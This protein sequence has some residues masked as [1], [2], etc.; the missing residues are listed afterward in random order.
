M[1]QKNLIIT[2]DMMIADIIQKY[3]QTINPLMDNGVHYLGCSASS[4][5]SINESLEMG[6][7]KHGKSVK[8]LKELIKMLNKIIE[9]ANLG[10][11]VIDDNDAKFS[12][13]KAAKSKIRE[14]LKK[15]KMKG[16][17]ISVVA[18]GC[19]GLKYGLEFSNKS[20]KNDIIIDE[21]GFKVF[22]EKES[23]EKINGARL[24]YED[25]LQGTGFKIEN[26]N[27]TKKC[28]CGNS[29]R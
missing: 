2:K 27:A 18:G 4:S 16:L 25:G 24:N 7:K 21:D 12:V 13:T 14:M 28:G 29:F 23:M 8:E 10:K 26:P 11:K 5:E 1:E 19:S 15:E 22:I 6:F 17:R 9:D 3:P 20:S